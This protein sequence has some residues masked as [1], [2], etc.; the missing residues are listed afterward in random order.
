MRGTVTDTNMSS[1]GVL[2]CNTARTAR[3]QHVVDFAGAQA[4]LAKDQL[5]LRVLDD[6]Q[7]LQNGCNRF[8]SLGKLLCFGVLSILP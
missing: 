8:M 7:G 4:G 3:S 6:L 2:L 5:D 1:P